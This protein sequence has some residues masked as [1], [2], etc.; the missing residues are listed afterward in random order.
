MNAARLD[1]PATLARHLAGLVASDPRLEPIVAVAGPL[2]VRRFDVGF[3]GL[4]R[5]VCGQMLSVASAN[6]IWARLCALEG[7]LA[8]ASFLELGEAEV[9]G[10]G[11]SG[12]KYATLRAIAEAVAGASLDLDALHGLS[13]DEAVA[14]LCA[15]KGVGPW[16]AEIYLLFCAGHADV[17][18][19]GDLAL[20]K[21]VAHGLGLDTRPTSKAL[22]QLASAWAPHRGAAA[23]LFWRYHAAMRL[24]TG[25]PL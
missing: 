21:A 3:A 18:P 17:F 1:S 25:A 9:R 7:A 8:P 11:L 4:A 10:A 16:T 6:A 20:Q 22:K 2:E 14:Q 12:G 19:A 13:A 23:L 15:L 5:V 24:S